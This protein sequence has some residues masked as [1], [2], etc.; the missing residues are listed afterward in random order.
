MLLTKKNYPSN[1]LEFKNTPKVIFLRCLQNLVLFWK[2]DC[3][4]F[5][6]W[7]DFQPNCK[8]FLCFYF[9]RNLIN[10][11]NNIWKIRVQLKILEIHLVCP[12]II[13]R[14]LS[15]FLSFTFWVEKIKLTSCKINVAAHISH[16][17]ACILKR[18]YDSTTQT[19]NCVA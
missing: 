4:F 12:K 14:S 3:T 13:S 19:I 7:W 9:M 16:N 6:K 11:S 15:L 18:K 17:R 2:S 5:F 10:Y 1:V 8:N